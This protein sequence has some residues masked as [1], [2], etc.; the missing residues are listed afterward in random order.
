MINTIHMILEVKDR[1]KQP[2]IVNESR[3][4]ILAQ[5]KYIPKARVEDGSLL[6]AQLGR[7]NPNNYHS[8]KVRSR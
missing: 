5:Y 1:E 7:N 3:K 8:P 2:E 4:A 6:L